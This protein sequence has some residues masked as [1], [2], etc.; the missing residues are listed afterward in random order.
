MTTRL[1]RWS[2]AHPAPWISLADDRV[3]WVP[4]DIPQPLTVR[5]RQ[6][7]DRMRPFGLGGGKAINVFMTDL[8]LP[9]AARTRWP[10]LVDAQDNI[11]WLVGQRCGEECRLADGV[12]SAWEVRLEAIS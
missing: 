9:R 2:P 11:L 8:K 5:P 12:T 3:I 4:E 10:L 1:R 7:G 6:P